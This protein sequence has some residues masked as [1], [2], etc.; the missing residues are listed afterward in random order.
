MQYPLHDQPLCRCVWAFD[1]TAPSCK[2]R[3]LYGSS[4]LQGCLSQ[5]L[6]DCVGVLTGQQQLLCLARVLLRRP[7]IV[8]LDE[9]T[10]SVDPRTAELMQEL[11]A[12]E[13]SSATIIQVCHMPQ[14]CTM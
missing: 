4:S 2:S 7:R 1:S 3:L 13:L 12:K 8:C 10:A 14:A 11:I 5:N 6:C 9:C